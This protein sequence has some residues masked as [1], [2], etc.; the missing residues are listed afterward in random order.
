MGGMA[1]AGGMAALQLG[2]SYMAGQ[3]QEEAYAM[4]A[5]QAGLEAKSA[6]L[7]RRSELQ[8]AL[9]M[10]AVIAGASGRAAGEGSVATIRQADISRAGEDI[11]MIKA[12]GKARAAGLRS[13]GKSAKRTAIT[14]GIL[15]AAGTAYKAKQVK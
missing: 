13:A 1:L 4:D 7:G 6:E 3:A 11:S 8:D 15:S 10:Q 5:E 14:S 2:T 9:A 12:G